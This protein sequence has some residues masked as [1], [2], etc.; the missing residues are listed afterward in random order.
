M[1][2]MLRVDV[3]PIAHNVKVLT[4]KAARDPAIFIRNLLQ[5]EP[6]VKTLPI[7]FGSGM[8]FASS[9]PRTMIIDGEVVEII[10]EVPIP[11]NRTPQ[12]RTANPIRYETPL[13]SPSI[14][15]IV[16]VDPRYPEL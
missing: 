8:L 3:K 9:F 7:R 1:D 6:P 11:V 5:K 14:G 10:S 4:D 13:P 16:N 2:W 12:H 15:R